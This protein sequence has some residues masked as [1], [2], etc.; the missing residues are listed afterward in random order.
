MI[1]GAGHH[2]GDRARALPLTEAP[3]AAAAH[4]VSEADIRG[5]VDSFYVAVRRDDV[6]GPVFAGH[7]A[8]WSL[9][10]PKMYDFWSTVILRTGRY[11]G[12]PFEVHRAIPGLSPAHFERWL[13]LWETTVARAFSREE[14]RAAFVVA[15][16]RMG[17]SMVARL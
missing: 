15:A 10:L 7:V 2:T 12:R 16:H 9:H 1:G 13:A 11:A 17:A 4:A 8:D 6:L 14:T 3:R 5:L